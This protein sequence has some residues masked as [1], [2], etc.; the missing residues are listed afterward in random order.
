MAFV[1]EDGTGLENA[2]SYIS[3]ADARAYWIEQAVV[4][5]QADTAAAGIVSLET[6]LIAAARYMELRFRSRYRGCIEFPP[7]DDG[8]FTGQALAF[9]RLNLYN[10]D[11]Y[12]VTGVPLKVQQAQAEY[13]KRVLD[14]G[15]TSLLPDPTQA[16]N[17]IREKV[18]PIE[19]E[20]TPGSVQI[21]HPYPTADNLLREFL[22]SGTYST[23]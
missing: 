5:T 12:L 11:G 20:Y 2:N 6:A 23:R 21:I 8:V 7:S 19:T 18:G 16:G 3:A 15:P 17:M 14:A 13:M 9:P 1:V 22:Y 10:F 4:F